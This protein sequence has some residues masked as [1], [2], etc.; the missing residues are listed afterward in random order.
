MPALRY[1]TVAASS[2][3]LPLRPALFSLPPWPLLVHTSL[4]TLCMCQEL[5]SPILPGTIMER[6][7]L[8]N[9]GMLL[10]MEVKGS[11][12]QA[13]QGGKEWGPAT[14]LP[15]SATQQ[16]RVPGPG[17]CQMLVTGLALGSFWS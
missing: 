16:M 15:F 7:K 4:Q 11:C 3:L 13:R 6:T 5:I 8:E 2:T 17:L 12:E 1:F 14:C 10:R 9:P